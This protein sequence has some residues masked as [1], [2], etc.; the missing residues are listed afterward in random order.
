M[1]LKQSINEAEK[2]ELDSLDSKKQ[3]QIKSIQ[4]HVG[5]KLDRDSI[6]DGVHGVIVNFDVNTRMGRLS[7]NQ[8]KGLVKNKIRWVEVHSQDNIISVGI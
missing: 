3:N 1:K 5:G 6:F 2:V 4:R 8:L 7:V